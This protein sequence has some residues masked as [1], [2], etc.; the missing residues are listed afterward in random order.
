MS[1][2]FLSPWLAAACFSVLGANPSPFIVSTTPA[3][4]S[5][6]APRGADLALTFSDNI[7]GGTASKIRVF[8]GQAGGRKLGAFSTVGKTVTFNPNT[9]FKPGELVN[10]SVPATVQST[11]GGF[12][13]VPHV[14]QFTAAATGGLGTFGPVI[15]VPDAGFS[16]NATLADVN[17]DGKLDALGVDLSGTDAAVRLGTGTGSFLAATTLNVGALPDEIVAADIDGDGDLDLLIGNG[18]A[19]GHLTTRF[20]DGTGIFSGGAALTLGNN[21]GPVTAADV[22]GDGDLDALVAISGLDQ[23][24][25]CRNNGSGVFTVGST[26]AVGD[27]PTDIAAGDVDGD[28]DLDL[29]TA[30]DLG[31]NITLRLNDGTGTF[32]GGGT[33]SAGDGAVS[34][35]LGDI[36]GDGD[37]DFIVANL[38]AGTVSVRRN[39][40]SGAFSA[41][42]TLAVGALA[43]Q[44]NLGDLDGD[45]DLD[46]LVTTSGGAVLGRNSGTGTFGLEALGNSTGLTLTV[47]DLDNDG[48]LDMVSRNSTVARLTARLNQ[49]AFLV[50]AVSPARNDA[51]ALRGTNVGITF[52][53]NVN[54]GTSNRI[55]IWGQQRGGKK[56]GVYSTS[57]NTVTFNP[58]TNFAPGEV[59]NVTVPTT[60]VSSGGSLARK[61]VYQ[62]TAAVTG[63]QGTFTNGTDISTG[64][65]ASAVATADV[66]GDGLLD[67]VA[68]G[69]SNQIRTYPGNGNGTFGVGVLVGT[70][71]ECYSLIPADLDN[72]GDMD[73]LASSYNNDQV[74]VY[75]N[76]GAGTFGAGVAVSVGD[77]PGVI[78]VGDLDGDGDL[79]FVAANY[80]GATVSVRLNN[81][82]GGF[83]AAANVATGNL[84]AGMA[85]GD[86]DGDGDLDLVSSY[87]NFTN[88]RLNNGSG[89]FSG[90]S[91]V[92]TVGGNGAFLRD[93]DGD[94]D[95]DL[96]V[97]SVNGR[98]SIS[99]NDGTGIFGNTLE[100]LSDN[101]SF[102]A[103][104][105]DFDGDG[106]LDIVLVDGGEN[107]DNLASLWLNN[108]DATFV[109][110]TPISSPAGYAVAQGDLDNDGDLDLLTTDFGNGVGVISVR[111]N[112]NAFTVTARAPERHT[113]TTVTSGDVNLTLSEAINPSTANQLRVFGSQSSGRKGG[114]FAG[115][116]T[117]L[118]LDPLVDFAP[119]EMV[120]VTA[121]ATIKTVGNV[122]S[123]RPH[124]YQFRAKATGG[125]GTFTN[126]PNVATSSAVGKVGI[127]DVN[128]DGN[129]DLLIPNNLDQ[130]VS[131]ALGA[132]DG[133]FG[134]L[135][136]VAVD[137]R[138]S[139]AVP[140]DV[141]ADGDL[142]LVTTNSITDRVSIRFNNGSGV[143]S[144]TGFVSVGDS[145]LHMTS[146]D[147]DG[148]GDLDI[149]TAN[150]YDQSLSV[151]LNNGSGVFGGG[152]T[153]PV[154]NEPADVVLADV[155]N[156][157]D[158]DLLT[159]NYDD[160][161][162]SIAFNLGTG[163]F[164][165][166]T[167][168]SVGTLPASLAMADVDH[169]GDLDML[170]GLA[171]GGV[172][173]H[174]N[175]GAGTFGAGTF[176]PLGM[177]L[178][179][180]IAADVDGDTDMDFIAANYS[181]ASFSVRLNDGTG[182]FSAVADVPVGFAPVYLAAADLDNDGDLDVA[183]V[184]QNNTL[185]IR[186]NGA[187]AGPA[188]TI[189][190][191]TPDHGVT[192]TVVT[193]TG[194]NFTGATAVTF[195]G[196]PAPGFAIA[197]GGTTITVASP[198]AT[199]NGVIT[200]T[201]PD[202]DASTA[203]DFGVDLIISAVETIPA[204]DFH[205]ITVTPTGAA[206][207]GG[208]VEATAEVL[209]QTGGEL[210]D[211]GGT[212]SGSGSITLDAGA[213][214]R[215]RNAQGLN[216]TGALQLTGGLNLDA[217]ATYIYQAA[218]AQVTG[219]N[220][221]TEV[222]NLTIDNTVGV[223][224][225]QPVNVRRVLTMANSGNFAANG[226]LTLLSDATGTAM[227][228]NA[229]TGIVSGSAT[230]QVYINPTSN[231]GLGYRHLSAP[232][233]NSTVAD[234][235]TT[236]FTA[237]VNP[238]YNANPGSLNGGNF[239]NVFGYDESRLPGSQVFS[240]GY[241]SPQALTDNLTNGRGYAV[242]MSGGR[243]PD[244]TGTLATGPVLLP[245]T[246]TG[247]SV[248][249]TDKAGW[250]LGGNP[251]PAP[252]RWDA[253]PSSAFPVNM[254]QSVSVFKS[255]GAN[256][257]IYLT[258]VN[259]MGTLPNG[260]IGVGQGIFLRLTSG[261]SAS[262][263]F[264]NAY[265]ATTYTSPIHFRPAVADAR[266]VVGL[267]LAATTAGAVADEAL[268]YFQAG[269]T[270]ALDNAFDGPK[271]GRNPGAVP[272]LV[273][274]SA[275]SDELAINGLSLESLTTG[276]RLPLLAVAPAAGEYALT[277]SQLANLDGQSVA[278]FDAL[279]GTVTPLTVGQTYRFTTPAAGEIRNRFWLNVQPAIVVTGTGTAAAMPATPLTVYPNPAHGTVHLLGATP[280]AP[281]LLIDALGRTVRTLPA[282]TT[283]LDLP[284]IPAGVYTIRT[285]TATARLVVE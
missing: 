27:G 79:D 36:D 88:V 45:G 122:K 175:L 39:N 197:G 255:T 132:G 149:V 14:Y 240:D 121:R 2:L 115:S 250:A 35:A 70:A 161:T 222:R 258:R 266:P 180:V 168:R 186:L 94:E 154:G 138:P 11:P 97:N 110:G 192:G 223:S 147:V 112:E 215:L 164:A 162:V 174:R 189:A 128:A 28:G 173:L 257:G 199:F 284:G 103:T 116:G 182:N 131:I 225:T 220:L 34:L 42:A 114:V 274:L 170:V 86:V 254:S 104:V 85:L 177:T 107:G 96:I 273:S 100:L 40:G 9:S 60:V 234:L 242:Y 31:D 113:A 142:D 139:K 26:L 233:T 63:G 226:N 190:S 15:D 191:F 251:Y 43:R 204:G 165:A 171:S 163:T 221:P 23:V 92:A 129:Q 6:T 13:A 181:S 71:S 153:V 10:V 7:S 155:D 218:Q 46:F 249:N 56:A 119:G 209:V 261:E 18:G 4:H 235:T 57:T 285:G 77:G 144:G 264:E 38:L 160:A 19:P 32:G 211:G 87:N 108:G 127:A 145:P 239:P 200:V 25:V 263:S 137:G 196:V 106:D 117:S 259:G 246:R 135:T 176:Y 102:E 44:A 98:L 208:A 166:P 123:L 89:G 183:V 198:P 37:L 281:V 16:S 134:A 64:G 206:T 248:G 224:L 269:A 68:C 253:V 3:R 275:A 270:A 84:A 118:S 52:S 219:S 8:G 33:V 188:P 136:T 54:N 75:L 169:D 195:D 262:F 130:S 193:I 152:S 29:L 151:R 194:T 185:S 93:M 83:S 203:T 143:F 245:L 230:A 227:V 120:D 12:S 213:T 78:A 179:E 66:T 247:L 252:L 244:F 17:G 277:V 212:L 81:G 150:Y 278:L 74:I 91:T 61:N 50:T 109:A 202:G 232:T 178:Y 267:T 148:D 228:V 231:A 260:E 111:L 243:T 216:P 141:D 159:P 125:S 22:D 80:L 157:G 272:T 265:R 5:V 283:T 146:G 72:D 256:N 105:G 236:G 237:L 30:N 82:S 187:V 205:H 156:D 55:R 282:G 172:S 95:L 24:T 76:N 133:T 73:L 241:F 140:M 48:D 20:N 279:T 158:L 126:A 271:P 184:N 65:D 1:N 229:G 214:L 59:V 62:F 53:Q 69:G 21:A 276:Q 99:L 210:A 280:G 90:G 268:V 67:V 167:L 201:T 41:A 49:N 217:D 238:V 101:L 124:V 51:N 47:G 58:T 207:L